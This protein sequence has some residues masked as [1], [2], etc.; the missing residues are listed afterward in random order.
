MCMFN[1]VYKQVIYT[2]YIPLIDCVCLHT[3]VFLFD[4]LGVIPSSYTITQSLI[5]FPISLPL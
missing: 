2:T 5:S 1:C 4:Q 3:D